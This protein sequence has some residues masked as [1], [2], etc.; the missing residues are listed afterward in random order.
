MLVTILMPLAA[1]SGSTARIRCFQQR[2]VAGLGIF[3]PRLLRQRHRALAEAFEHEIVDLAL[4]G[5][6]DRGLDAVARIAGA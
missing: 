6:F 1:Q 3:H 4:L 5:E 2:I